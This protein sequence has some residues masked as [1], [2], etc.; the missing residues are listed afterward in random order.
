MAIICTQLSVYHLVGEPM[1]NK[2]NVLPWIMKVV[3]PSKIVKIVNA[4]VGDKIA[5]ILQLI[6]Y[7]HLGHFSILVGP[8]TCLIQNQYLPL[9]PQLNDFKSWFPLDLYVSVRI[10]Y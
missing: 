1:F 10:F 3:G 4:E 8:T 2:C 6:G 5:N 7:S 9:T